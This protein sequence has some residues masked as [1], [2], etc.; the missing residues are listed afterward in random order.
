MHHRTATYLLEERGHVGVSGRVDV[1]S[2]FGI[3]VLRH[4]AC[5]LLMSPQFHPTILKPGLHLKTH[6]H[7]AALSLGVQESAKI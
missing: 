4:P 7:T 3:E 5:V 2:L 1:A 6:T